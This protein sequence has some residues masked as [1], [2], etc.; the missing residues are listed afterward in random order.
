MVPSMG[1]SSSTGPS[2]ADE[3][4]PAFGILEGKVWRHLREGEFCFV[5]ETVTKLR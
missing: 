4:I 2:P 3:I 5:T 1:S